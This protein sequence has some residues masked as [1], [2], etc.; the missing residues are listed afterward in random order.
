MQADC[1]SLHERLESRHQE[2][3]TAESVHQQQMASCLSETEAARDQ[4]R[5]RHKQELQEIEAKL[6]R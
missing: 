3:M 1:A 2:L 4:N 6:Q 5:N